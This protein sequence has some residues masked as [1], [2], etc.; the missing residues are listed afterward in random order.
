MIELR[1]R[2]S[3]RNSVG[4]QRLSLD[5]DE[6]D[7]DEEEDVPLLNRSVPIS[8]P[9]E[10]SSCTFLLFFTIVKYYTQSLLV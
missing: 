1:Q 10:S 3:S 7:I 5:E 6:L 9:V 2:S 4:Y 8:H